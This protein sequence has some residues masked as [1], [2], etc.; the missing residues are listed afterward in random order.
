M[1][2]A[3]RHYPILLTGD[4]DELNPVEVDNAVRNTLMAVFALQEDVT[5]M[6]EKVGGAIR[7]G[8]IAEDDTAAAVSTV[9]NATRVVIQ[10]S[11]TTITGTKL[12]NPISGRLSVVN[13]A[14]ELEGGVNAPEYNLS[15]KTLTIRGALNITGASALTG[16]VTIGGTINVAGAATL[17]STLAVT[18]VVTLSSTLGV[19]GTTTLDGIQII[20]ITS[21]EALLVRKNADGG[22]VFTVNTTTPGVLIA[23]TLNV[24]GALT[25]TVPLAVPQGGTG[26][27]TFTDHGLMVGSGTGILTVLGSATNGQLPIGNTGSDPTLATLTGTADEITVSNGGGT[28]TLSQPNDVTIGGILTVTGNLNHDGTNIG[29]FGT[30]PA[31]QAASY[32]RNATVVEDRTLLASASAT[33]LNNNN[34]LAALIADLQSYGLIQ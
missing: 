20:D 21:T 31:V 1:P 22:D 4:K 34:V 27:A 29:F 3:K 8:E 25:L 9:A 33:T 19:T 2:I 30:A 26:A 32:T 13:A 14:L 11:P 28:I 17:Q 12:V 6:Q 15:T 10:S 5:L 16:N 18:G 24:T 7:R 23:G